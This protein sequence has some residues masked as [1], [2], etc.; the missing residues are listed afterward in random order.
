MRTGLLIREIDYIVQN[1]QIEMK[2]IFDNPFSQG[3]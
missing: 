1:K 2:R 3:K